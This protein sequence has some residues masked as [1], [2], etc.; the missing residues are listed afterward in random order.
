VDIDVIREYCLKKEGKI[1]EG[2][3]FGEDVLVFKVEG[4][5]FLLMRLM[6]RPLKINLKCD[7]ERALE[8]RER[9]ESV[10]PGYHMN[11]KL[12]NTV[13]LDGKIPPKEVFGM[14]DHSYDEVSKGIRKSKR[15]P[16]KHQ[17]RRHGA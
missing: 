17:N 7:P 1:T 13:I 11:K 2:M 12:W 8:L 15:N 4:R 10:L 6:Q 14:I 9:Y 5:I 3:P 16:A